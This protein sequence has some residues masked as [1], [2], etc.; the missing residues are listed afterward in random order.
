MEHRDYV[1]LKERAAEWNSGPGSALLKLADRFNVK[2]TL[3]Y[4]WEAECE[5]T[6]YGAIHERHLSKR[7][8][9]ALEGIKRRVIEL[10]K[11]QN[12]LIEWDKH[13]LYGYRFPVIANKVNVEIL[14]IRFLN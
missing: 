14:P 1:K 3:L 11:E 8:I 2:Y 7:D 9:A 4:L 13:P 10:A 6:N 12:V 5:L